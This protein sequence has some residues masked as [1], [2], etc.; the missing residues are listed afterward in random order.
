MANAQNKLKPTPPE[1]EGPFYPVVAQADT[2]F[3]LTQIQG[4][5]QKSQSTMPVLIFGKLTM[6]AAIDTPVIL[7]QPLWMKTFKAGL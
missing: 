1:I 4:R 6:P 5:E 7:V 3:D 2:D